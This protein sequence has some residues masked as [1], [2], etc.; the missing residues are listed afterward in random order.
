MLRSL[1]SAT[2]V[3]HCPCTSFLLA[4]PDPAPDV[5]EV[6]GKVH[7]IESFSAVDGPGVRFLVFLQVCAPPAVRTTYPTLR[8]PFHT[9][10]PI[11][12]SQILSPPARAHTG[13]RPA[14]LLLQQPRHLGVRGE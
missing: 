2:A 9:I 7:S 6:W 3:R 11:Q 1:Q 12:P 14:L 5:P 10:L 8:L 4:P 13:L